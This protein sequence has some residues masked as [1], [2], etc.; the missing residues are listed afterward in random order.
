MRLKLAVL[1]AI[2]TNAAMGQPATANR[3]WYRSPAIH[4]DT[5]VFTAEGD[6]WLTGLEGG[7]ARRLTTNPGRESSA[8]F[9][10]DGATIAFAAE[11]E[12]P[13]EVYSMPATGGVPER[14]TFLGG[15]TRPVGWTNDGRILVATNAFS[16]LP[17][18]QL[19]TIAGDNQIQRLPLSQAAQGCYDTAGKTLFFTRLAWQG[20]YT[21]R[22]QGGTAENLWKYTQGA[23]GVALTGDYAGTSRNAMCWNDRVYFLT[24]RDGTMNLWSMDRDGK[25]VLQH[26]RHQGFDIKSASLSNGKVV[27][28]LGADLRLYDIKS[29]KDQLIPI[30]LPS[31]FDSLREHW[32]KNPMDYVSSVHLSSDGA[33]VVLTSRGRVFVAPAK[34]GQ[35]RLVNVNPREPGRFR[36]ARFMAD[37]KS[38]LMFSTATGEVELW[39]YP[40][41]GK[42][43]GQQ[44]T[45]D[46]T[47]L[48]W[49]A[50]PSPDG[51][52]IAHQDKDQQLWLYNIADKTNKKIA[53]SRNGDN[54]GPPF[55]ELRWSPDSRWIVFGENADNTF[56]QVMLYNLETGVKTP[57]TTDRYDSGS[58]AWSADGKWLYFVS[59]RALKSTVSA[60]WGS[61]L[62]DPY[63]D[64][65]MKVYELALKKGLVSPF[66]PSD[67]LHP[68]KPE[69]EKST[70]KPAEKPGEKS[71]EKPA[72]KAAEKSGAASGGEKS[73]VPRVEIELDGIAT[74]LQEVPIP[75]GNYRSLQVAGEKL[76]W[77]NDDAS[78]PAKSAL[79]CIKIANKGD[80]PETLFDGVKEYEVSGDGKKM[81]VRKKD[82]VFVFDSTLSADALKAPKTLSDA[83]VDLKSWTFSVIP[84]QEF[85]EAYLDAWRLER[86][87]FYDPGMHQVPW[88]TIRDKHLEFI[89]RIR[90]RDELSDLVSDMVSELS[91]LHTF[92]AGGDVRK[93]PDQIQVGSLGALL[94]RDE[95]AGGFRVEHIYR[96]DPD[97][98]DKLSPLL[99]PG[100]ELVDGDVITAV[101]GQSAL[102]VVHP[103]EL[104]RNQVD[105]QVLITYHHKGNSEP[106]DVV[107]KPISTRQESDLRYSEWE[108]TRRKTVEQA[109]KNRFGYI[110][111]RAM[112]PDDIRQWEEEYPPVFDRDGLIIDVRHNRGGNIDSW[113]LGKLLRKPWMYWQPRHGLPYWNL[114]GA[115]RG[116]VIVLCDQDTASDG[117]AF[118]EGFRRL[119]LGKVLGTR[120]WGGEIWLTASNRLADNGV[121]TAAELGVYGPERKWLIEGHG[122]DPDIV[123]DNLPHAT[124]EGQDAQLEA[125]IRYLTD[126]LKQHPNP[127]PAPPAY[128]DKR[129]AAKTGR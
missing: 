64:R 125:A 97:R 46:G 9:S 109:S 45:R 80:K 113:I 93:S 100:V 107:A 18:V 11:Y 26:T 57:V 31:N 66:A 76:C 16:G 106:H 14:R 34:A 25:H 63:F 117:E 74:R 29:G 19:A 40:A 92:V 56:Q 120:T 77:I 115:F 62:P 58:A 110:H 103:N 119:G 8:V 127:L 67:E 89:E 60:P 105:K 65:S 51:K 126:E 116:P 52:W 122:V 59:D 99:R 27:Y 35:G 44:L 53:T 28:Q 79:E 32:I 54:D 78:D 37:G 102:S 13:G 21:K 23:E 41:N 22:Y 123:V 30:S 1:A 61:R 96:T 91:A 95:S 114:Q 82:D 129:Y 36:E 85:R 38:A 69:A 75:P 3:G 83:Q 104:L 101:N 17:A 20:S 84:V 6:L 55:T 87:Y 112:G 118:A 12:G 33:S 5:I 4:G 98:P 71:S 49:D 94:T 90:D 47:I 88:K 111:L 81:L 7:L 50:V 2:V 42:G 70:E 73:A 124:F 48:R 10:P 15:G 128:P 86:D 108:F 121:A 72:E 39:L 68:P 24:D 43:A